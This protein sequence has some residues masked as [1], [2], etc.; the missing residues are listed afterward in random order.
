MSE[1]STIKLVGKD[2]E[3]E[4][5]ISKDGVRLS[6]LTSMEQVDDAVI[7]LPNV[8]PDCLEKDC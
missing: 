8:S 6:R 7:H 4:F 2:G 5:E 3:R 1:G